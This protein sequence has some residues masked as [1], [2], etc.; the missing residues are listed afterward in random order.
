[1]GQHGGPQFR[2]SRFASFQPARQVRKGETRP[3]QTSVRGSSAVL[4]NL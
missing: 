3:A 2:K 1:M 4:L